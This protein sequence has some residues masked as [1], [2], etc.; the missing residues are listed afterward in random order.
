MAVRTTAKHA[1]SLFCARFAVC[2]LL[3]AERDFAVCLC[4]YLCVVIPC[5]VSTCFP[6]VT[7]GHQPHAVRSFSKQQRGH[8]ARETHKIGTGRERKPSRHTSASL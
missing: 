8:T 5:R 3:L 7:H 2:V 4:D 1:A 6:H